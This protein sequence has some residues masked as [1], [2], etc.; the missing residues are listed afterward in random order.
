MA[1][2]SSMPPKKK[3]KLVVP[4]KP[5]ENFIRRSIYNHMKVNM[6]MFKTWYFK[7]DGK[8]IEKPEGLCNACA[9]EEK[10]HVHAVYDTKWA[11]Y[12]ICE[13]CAKM[14]QGCLNLNCLKNGK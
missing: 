4:V 2:T 7:V 10:K 12:Y 3:Q 5:D 6:R 13:D 11:Q 1:H 14:Y 8:T 9:C